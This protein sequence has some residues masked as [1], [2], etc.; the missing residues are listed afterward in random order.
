MAVAANLPTPVA[1]D[2][3]FTTNA[4]F[5]A[6]SVM[7]ALTTTATGSLPCSCRGCRYKRYHC[8]YCFCLGFYCCCCE[9]CYTFCLSERKAQRNP[10]KFARLRTVTR[11]RDERLCQFV[12]ANSVNFPT[13]AT[14]S[15]ATTDLAAFVSPVATAVQVSLLLLRRPLLRRPPRWP[16]LYLIL[17]SPV[18]LIGSAR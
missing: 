1:A 2:A 7:P 4:A 5:V 12:D 3:T 18:L 14:S 8:L 17:L 13:P 11:C 15:A 10:K 16:S 6:A 9:R